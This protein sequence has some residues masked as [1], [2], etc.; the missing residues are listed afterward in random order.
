[1]HCA[2]QD[3]NILTTK[4]FNDHVFVP[5]YSSFTI[6]AVKVFWEYNKIPDIVPIGGTVPDDAYEWK[7]LTGFVEIGRGRTILRGSPPM[8][9]VK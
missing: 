6:Q 8:D 5:I 9:L 3:D 4:K 1:M 7:V 2:Y